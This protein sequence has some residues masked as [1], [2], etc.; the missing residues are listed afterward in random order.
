MFND[1]QSCDDL[2]V[3]DCF[4]ECIIQEFGVQMVLDIRSVKPWAFGG[5][6]SHVSATRTL[7]KFVAEG[8]GVPF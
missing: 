1:R 3:M 8:Y 7:F 5:A 2:L 4:N 6:V